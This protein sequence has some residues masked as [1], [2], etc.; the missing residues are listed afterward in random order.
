MIL[1]LVSVSWNQIHR[2]FKIS[3]DRISSKMG[4]QWIFSRNFNDYK[5]L[6][7]KTRIVNLGYSNRVGKSNDLLCT[8]SLWKIIVKKIANIASTKRDNSYHT[9]FY[10]WLKKRKITPS[11]LPSL[12]SQRPLNPSAVFIILQVPLF[13]QK[14]ASGRH[15]LSSSQNSPT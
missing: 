9:L 3:S 8:I 7:I 14:W 6:A 13:S 15:G 1:V 11:C 4:Y 2:F 10:V 5:C 12:Q